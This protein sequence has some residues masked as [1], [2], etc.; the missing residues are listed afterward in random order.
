MEKFLLIFSCY[1]F[2][3]F[4]SC[5][6]DSRVGI[7][8]NNN[9]DNEVYVGDNIHV[10]K[11]AREIKKLKATIELSGNFL[12]EN[13]RISRFLEKNIGT[14]VYLDLLINDG[15]FNDISSPEPLG[16][17]NPYPESEF[18][19][20]GNRECTDIPIL[21]VEQYSKNIKSL[22]DSEKNKWNGVLSYSEQFWIRVFNINKSDTF[23]EGFGDYY[24]LKGHFKIEDVDGVDEGVFFALISP[25][26]VEEI[27]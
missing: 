21:N 2:V 14:I 18:D 8:G 1:T 7:Q 3:L 5:C 6:G 26:K 23:H 22:S 11:K 13:Y 20:F 25:V 4:L 19:E 9:N 15:S 16:I 24:T 12:E 10:E 17:E 27:Y